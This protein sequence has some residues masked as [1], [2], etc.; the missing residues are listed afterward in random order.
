MPVWPKK[1]EEMKVPGTKLAL[2]T[3]GQA[4]QDW[5]DSGSP[6]S[7]FR[8][9]ELKRTLRACN[10]G[11]QQLVSKDDQFRDY[12]NNPL[13]FLGKMVVTL[14]SNGWTTTASINVIGGFRPSIIARHLMSELGLML[15]QSQSEQWV[16]NIQQDGK[17]VEL[18]EDLDDWQRHFS[19]QFHHLFRRKGVS[20]IKKCRQNFSGI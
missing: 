14:Q 12:G 17:T 11:L 8:I 16:H 1:D 10:V 5:I 2:R 20:V 9:V 7:I 19:K 4:T 3:N 18:D 6:K 13:K 15:V